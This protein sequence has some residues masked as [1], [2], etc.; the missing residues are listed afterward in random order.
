MFITETK[1]NQLPAENDVRCLL[2]FTTPSEKFVLVFIN[3]PDR[4][5]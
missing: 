1:Q 5:M 4:L 3:Y 2:M